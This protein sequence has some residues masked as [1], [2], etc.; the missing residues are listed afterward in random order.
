[1]EI[2]PLA[3]ADVPALADGLAALPLMVRYGRDARALSRALEAALARGEGLLVAAQGG[4]PA[5]LAWF[6]PAGTL[7]LGGYLRLIAVLA[8]GEGKGVGAALLRAFEAETARASAHAFLLVS[9][10]NEAAQRFYVRE[11]YQRV[12]ALPGLVLPDVAE[13]LYW[14][15][16][17]PP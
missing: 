9:D 16:L 4:A 7:A 13:V 12:G 10:F 2:R 5:G 17:R 6:L 14:K 8:G 15:R 3:P 11:G 1:V